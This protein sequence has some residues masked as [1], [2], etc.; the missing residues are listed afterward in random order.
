M[1]TNE[2][3][4]PDC[5]EPWTSIDDKLIYFPFVRT[6]N[7]EIPGNILSRRAIDCVNA[8]AGMA[9]PAAEIQAMR[10]AIKKAYEALYSSQ[11]VMRNIFPEPAHKGPC[12]PDAGCDASCMEASCLAGMLQKV[13]SAMEKLN[14]FCPQSHEH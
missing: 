8:C 7:D 10:E 14:S 1:K 5:G 12:G 11:F 9:D 13:E 2:Q 4:T 3:P 6:R